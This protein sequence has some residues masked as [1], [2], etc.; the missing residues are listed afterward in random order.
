M[1]ISA[2]L[3]RLQRIPPADEPIHLS[4]RYIYILPTKFGIIYALLLLGMLVGSINYQINTGYA[5]VFLMAGTALVSM[6]HTFGNMIGLNIGTGTPEPVFAGETACFPVYLQETSGRNRYSIEFRE[7]GPGTSY[8]ANAHENVSGFV[9]S[10]STSRGWKKLKRFSL[11]TTYPLGLFRA[12]AS[13]HVDVYCLVYPRPATDIPRDHVSD[14]NNKPGNAA[15]NPTQAGSEDF[16]KL[17]DAQPGD[18][19]RRIDWKAFARQKGLVVKQFSSQEQKVFWMD[20]DGLPVSGTE[21]KL[22]ILCRF[23]L[24]CH[25]SGQ[26]YGMKLPGIRISPDLG[27]EHKQACLKALA[28][29]G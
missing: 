23:V 15:N 20:F 4:R 25:D 3:S 6:L 2:I 9:Y 26:E 5:L 7:T 16:M 27:D 18:P 14:L 19:Y 13:I 17:R 12:W 10:E 1:Q 28:L 11:S 22:S 24:D 8:H 21:N 29:F